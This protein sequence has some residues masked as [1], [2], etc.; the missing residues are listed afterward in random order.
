MRVLRAHL[1]V[2]VLPNDDIG[3]V[4]AVDVSQFVHVGTADDGAGEVGVLEDRAGQV[5][6]PEVRVGEVGAG[7]VR[8]RQVGA[9]EGDAREIAAAELGAL[10]RALGLGN[11]RGP[12]LFV[13][14]QIAE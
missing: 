14:S 7:E 12:G 10:E 9:E 3:P 2:D 4:R 13:A 8:V 6:L 5:A 11:W 1:I